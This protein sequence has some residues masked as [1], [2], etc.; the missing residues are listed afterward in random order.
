MAKNS[1]KD[2]MINNWVNTFDVKKCLPPELTVE[3]VDDILYRIG[4]SFD[5]IR[6]RPKRKLKDH[7][8]F[9]LIVNLIILIKDIIA[10][11][12]EEE[13]DIGFKIVGAYG[14]FIG[15][16]KQMCLL[17]YLMTSLIAGSQL[18]YYYNY[19][20]GIKPTFLRVFQM[21]SGLVSPKSLGLTDGKEVTKLVKTMKR[22]YWIIRFNTDR[23]LIFF[24]PIFTLTIYFF[25]GQPYDTIKFGIYNAILLF[26]WANHYFNLFLYQFFVFYIICLYLKMKINSL[27]E[28]LIEMKRR[29]R[30]IRIRET[31]Q[32]FDSLYL[33]INEYNTTFWSKFLILIWL[34]FSSQITLILNLILFLDI[35][36]ALLLLFSYFL[37]L[38][39]QIF[40]FVI[41]TAS[42]V[43][44]SANK[45]Y[46]ILNSLFISYSK[47]NCRPLNVFT[48]L[49][50]ILPQVETLINFYFNQ[51]QNFIARTAEKRVGF[52]CW[53]L[54][55]INYFR[56]YE[57]SRF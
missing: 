42:S 13:N 46:K 41:F 12:L 8:I 44:T 17:S 40:L 26:F 6:D 23:V 22:L 16:R 19:R 55:T 53:V 14:Y 7:P 9:V 15:L 21:M 20:N 35:N 50:V 45:S 48:K 27:N 39:I 38:L 25:Y 31:L 28:R 5:S 2:P 54:F 30:F 24:G 11:S 57:V 33:E 1:P 4:L 49:K 29:K 36:L 47:R 51:L 43:N 10:V 52:S 18:I 32:S 37:F 3:S 34:I 56:C